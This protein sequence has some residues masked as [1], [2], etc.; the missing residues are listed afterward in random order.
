MGTRAPIGLTMLI[1]GQNSYDNIS[2]GNMPGENQSKWHMSAKCPALRLR[3][4][5]SK[6]S[7]EQ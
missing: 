6:P 3:Q 2:G 4:C 7:S 5:M 1:V